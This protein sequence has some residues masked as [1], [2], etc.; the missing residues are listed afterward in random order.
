LVDI[1]HYTEMMI[2]GLSKKI[3]ALEE[4]LNTAEKE[5]D[6]ARRELCELTASLASLS[7][8]ASKE[9]WLLAETER[10][11]WTHLFEEKE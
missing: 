2:E 5:R 4:K 10:R 8:P 7:N 6:E 11:G 9:R 3:H 1:S